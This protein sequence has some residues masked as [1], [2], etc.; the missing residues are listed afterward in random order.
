MEKF[1]K[2]LQL[3][4]ILFVCDSNGPY[5]IHGGKSVLI[6]KGGKSVL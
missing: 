5:Q 6:V 2:V 3:I 1:F 4:F